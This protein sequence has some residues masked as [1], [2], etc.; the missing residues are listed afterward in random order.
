MGIYKRGGNWFVDYYDQ[1]HT[2]VQESSHS[3]RRTDAEA[4][5]SVR[6]SE[7]LRGVY[8]RPVK[9]AFGEF[10]KRYMEHAKANKRSWSRD[11]QMLGHL[12]G[13]LGAERQLAEI[14]ASDIEG[15]KLNRKAKVS[16]STVNRELALL[17]RMFNLA[18]SWDLYLDLNPFRKVKFFREINIGLRFV[19][20][21]E[22][23]RLLRNASPYVQDIVLFALNTGLRIGEIY[24]LQ[25]ANVD[26]EKN[27]L[28]VF[29]PKTQK[30]RTVPIND[31]ARK[32]LEYWSLGRGTN[33]FSTIP[34]QALGLL[35]SRQ[36]SLWRAERPGLKV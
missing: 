36:A 9:I 15:Y 16:G 26:L 12:K 24:G 8:K 7:V 32:V 17:K 35:I 33:S 13:F 10:G 27:L 1:N 25:W 18:I 29:A 2:R 6:K 21:G 22:E 19:T 31:V 11:E 4:L 23:E 3:S 14:T 5:L 30:T 34:K 20:P 28:N